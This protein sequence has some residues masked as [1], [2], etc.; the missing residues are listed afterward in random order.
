MRHSRKALIGVVLWAAAA[1]APVG[2]WP[3]DAGSA[4]PLAQRVQ[5]LLR[6]GGLEYEVSVEPTLQGRSMPAGF[7]VD[8]V[9]VLFDV[10]LP[11]RGLAYDMLGPKHLCLRALQ[12]PWF[13]PQQPGQQIPAVFAGRRRRMELDAVAAQT[14]V[15]SLEAYYGM[16]VLLDYRIAAHRPIR[17]RVEAD[18]LEEALLALQRTQGWQWFTVESL[19]VILPSAEE[20]LLGLPNQRAQKWIYAGVPLDELLSEWASS[21]HVDFELS[22]TLPP[23]MV[24]GV[25]GGATLGELLD[26]LGALCECSYAV[27]ERRIYLA[28][29]AEFA[30]YRL[31]DEQP[32]V[33]IDLEVLEVPEKRW[34]SL[35]VAEF[36]TQFPPPDSGQQEAFVEKV[37]KTSGVRSFARTSALVASGTETTVNFPLG[38]GTEAGYFFRILP[39]ARETE[40]IHLQVAMEFREPLPSGGPSRPPG[41]KLFELPVHARVVAGDRQLLL[42]QGA[43]W[44]REKDTCV[45]LIALRPTLQE[46]VPGFAPRLSSEQPRWHLPWQLEAGGEVQVIGIHSSGLPTETR[47]IQGGLSP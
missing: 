18:S 3:S 33:R 42:L 26:Q 12:R 32:K 45:F 36:L 14:V 6:T 43:A 9:E 39:L 46:P 11:A 20:Q 31:S 13:G 24:S 30:L 37:R 23:K 27:A 21:F 2:G 38:K 17:G 28:P 15:Q 8:S 41:K 40:W 22:S 5:A 19:L 1:V 10:V 34:R 25:F 35:R 29:K 16:P 47:K 4:T 7:L 44:K